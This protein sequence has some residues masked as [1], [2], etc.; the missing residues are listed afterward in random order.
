MKISTAVA[1]L[2]VV[3]QAWAFVPLHHSHQ[4]LSTSVLRMGKVPYDAAAREAYDEWRAKYSKG[5]FDSKRFDIFKANYETITVANVAAKKEARE[6]GVKAPPLLTLNEFGD[7]TE[8]EYK[9][10]VEGG[11]SKKGTGDVLGKAL[12]AAQSQSEASSALED[13]ANALAEDEEVRR[14]CSLL[15]QAKHGSNS[16]SERFYV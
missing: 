4:S 9:A 6:S 15:I 13:A 16:H 11:S 8:E 1:F 12:E 10:A 7:C 2:V 3:S 5:A 14:A